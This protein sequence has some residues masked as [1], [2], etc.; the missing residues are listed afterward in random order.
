MGPFSPRMV[1][2]WPPGVVG[3][4]PACKLHHLL[5]TLGLAFLSTRLG[6]DQ[7]QP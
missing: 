1:V 5:C 2:G 3:L 6:A 7:R 4:C